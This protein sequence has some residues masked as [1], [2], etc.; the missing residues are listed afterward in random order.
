[1]GFDTWT[2]KTLPAQASRAYAEPLVLLHGWGCD[3]RSWQPVL[4]TLNQT[5]DVILVDL[6][7]F[8][9]VG[10]PEIIQTPDDFC[11][12]LIAAL[13]D[14]FL[15]LGWSLGGMLATRLAAQ[16]PQR[17]L[18]LMTLASN[19][20]FVSADDWPSAMSRNEFDAFTL[21]F[22][23]SPE[24]TLKRFAGLM[25]KG[26]A[27]NERSLLKTLRQESQAAWQESGKKQL[28]W[29]VGLSWLNDLD[30][31]QN[32]SSL[33]PPGLHLLAENDALVPSHVAEA[34]A[35]LNRQQKIKVLDGCAHALHWSDPQKVT[36]EILSFVDSVHYAVDKRKV[37]ESFGRAAEKYDSVASLQRQ[38][39][40]HLLDQMANDNDDND[41]NW[42]DLGCGTGY[43]TSQLNE[44]CESV[45]GLDLS[46]GML[47]YS[48]KTHS[49]G[50]IQ[51]LCGDAEAVPLAD[52][53]LNGVF[54]SL[55]IQWCANLPQL[56]AELNR[57]LKPGG[58]LYL[59]TLGPGTLHEL[60]A[61][62]NEV[63][64]Y[65]HVNHFAAEAD[66]RAAIA[67]NGLTLDDWQSESIVL[68]Y[69]QVRDLTYELKTLG[70][71]NMNHGQSS[72]LTGRQRI[73][74]FKQAY[75]QFRQNDG[76]LPATYEAFY[77]Q[78]TKSEQD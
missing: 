39:G 46:E 73:T 52:G 4:E 42:L 78:L 11:S 47:A 65:T 59:A 77:L 7:G 50:S 1:M 17:V 19:L 22:D 14:R 35:V 55:A 41:G 62:W 25:V 12:K 67:D 33:T 32:F 24:L 21:G 3:S 51:W 63:D 44:C 71:H 58:R 49:S 60:R 15:L 64:K 69:D 75:E 56:F 30:N 2:F 68:Q 37:A 27:E 43:F 20:K 66:V 29:R 8:G 40:H 16:Y 26:D 6:P 31:R 23:E 53:S 45:F 5:L 72:G 48:R 9:D 36:Q 10:T 54:S 76:K 18:G 57:V 28:S 74:A 38:V 13:P 34:M 70:A 61:A